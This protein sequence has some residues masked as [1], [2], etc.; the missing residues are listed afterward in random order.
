M[1]G[2]FA[3]LDEGNFAFFARENPRVDLQSS[4]GA[5]SAAPFRYR[6]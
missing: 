5:S 4:H 1:A 6:A 3:G 2:N